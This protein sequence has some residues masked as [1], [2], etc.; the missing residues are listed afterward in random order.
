MSALNPYLIFTQPFHEVHTWIN[1]QL[2]VVGFQV[3]QT[4]DLQVARLS[5]SG[6]PCPN[7]GTDK[8]SCQMV[9]KQRMQKIE[10]ERLSDGISLS[11]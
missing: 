7:H 9:C 5:H 3:E 10:H 2:N 4:F 11:Q 6:C 1:Q 8:C